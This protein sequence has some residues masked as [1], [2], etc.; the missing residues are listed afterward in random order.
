M[1]S[2]EGLYTAL[3][4]PFHENGEIN[5]SALREL[6]SSN[7][8]KGI[9]GFYVCGSTGEAF[10]LSLDERKRVLS[11]VTDEAKDRVNIFC[12]IGAI[13]TDFSIDL[14]LHAKDVGVSAI[15]SIPP[16]YYKFTV[17]ELLGYYI[18]I[19]EE[20]DLPLIPYNFPG[21]SGV[22]LTSEMIASLRKHANIVGVKF[23]SN[24]LYQLQGMKANDPELLVFNGFDEIFLAGL[25]MGADGA[26]GST[27]NFMPEKYISILKAFKAGD[28]EL[29]RTKQAE[30]NEVIRVMLSTGHSMNAQ[31]YFLEK[32]GIAAGHSRRPFKPLTNE[33]KLSLDAVFEA[34]LQ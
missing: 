32:Q 34:Y 15:S 7:I 13:S 10:L 6:V 25:A 29:A 31:K 27:L 11:I 28:Y 33:E 17:E 23:T 24:D 2:L 18:D 19:S 21:L 1:K 16:F 12:H 5:E 4:T 22:S 26:I 9:D 20:V 14:G 30:A 8:D 3:L